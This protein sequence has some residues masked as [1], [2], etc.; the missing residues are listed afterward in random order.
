MRHSIA[1]QEVHQRST[2][3][4]PFIAHRREHEDLIE[5]EVFGEKSIKAYIGKYPAGYA[6]MTCRMTFEQ[7]AH[8]Q[9]HCV[10]QHLLNRCSDI[11]ALAFPS[12]LGQQLEYRSIVAEIGKDSPISIHTKMSADS[13]SENWLSHGRQAGELT[14]VPIIPKSERA[15]CG[16]IGL[17]KAI[18]RI[19]P[20]QPFIAAIY[21]IDLAIGKA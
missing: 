2:Y 1:L 11:F 8:R 21:F 5:I 15:R 14:F 12:D 6:E 7:P 17:S 19:V 16:S 18:D 4:Q 3:R 20:D 10:L 13:F 9:Q